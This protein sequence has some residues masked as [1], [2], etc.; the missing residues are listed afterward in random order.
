MKTLFASHNASNQN[1]SGGR[2][3]ANHS[4]STAK[5]SSCHVHSTLQVVGLLHHPPPLVPP[6]L[7]TQ[8]LRSV[9]YDIIK[10]NSGV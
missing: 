7:L 6:F 8:N 1:R 9:Q 3:G 10:V 2:P 4:S 5:P